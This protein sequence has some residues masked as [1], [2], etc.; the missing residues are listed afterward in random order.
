MEY[1]VVDYIVEWLLVAY[2]MAK[3]WRIYLITFS[4]GP[5]TRYTRTRTRT[6]GHT[7]THSDDSNR[8]ECN[9]L[10]LLNM[11]WES[12]TKVTCSVLTSKQKDK[13]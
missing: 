3:K 9:A 6:Q 12:N 4:A 7:H 8:R 5:L 1:N 13:K 2:K 10:D 11:F